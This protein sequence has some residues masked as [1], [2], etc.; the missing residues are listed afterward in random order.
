VSVL[1]CCRCCRCCCLLFLKCFQLHQ[2]TS[3][4]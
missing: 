4:F 3:C 2:L 1:R